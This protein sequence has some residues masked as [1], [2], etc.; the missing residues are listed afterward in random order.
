MGSSRLQVLPPLDVP[1]GWSASRFEGE[2]TREVSCGAYPRAVLVVVQRG[3][4]YGASYGDPSRGC[5]RV[6][7]SRA[8]RT[9][10]EAVEAVERSYC[11]CGVVG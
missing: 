3:S 1:A 11:G 7:L 8:F 10:R 5:A 4:E 2:W 9:L 6:W